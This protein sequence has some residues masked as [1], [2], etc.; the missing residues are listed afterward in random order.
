MANA[1]FSARLISRTNQRDHLPVSKTIK[2]VWK[3][4]NFSSHCLHICFC[5][6]VVAVANKKENSRWF[7]KN[8]GEGKKHIQPV[9]VS[10]CQRERAKFL[11]LHFFCSSCH[12]NDFVAGRWITTTPPNKKQS[13]ANQK[14][15]DSV[16]S[17]SVKWTVKSGWR[18]KTP[19]DYGICEDSPFISGFYHLLA[20]SFF[21]FCLHHSFIFSI[22]FSLFQK[23]GYQ[24]FF[25]LVSFSFATESYKRSEIQFHSFILHF[26]S[27]TKKKIII[28][29]F[30]MKWHLFS[31]NIVFNANYPI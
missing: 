4:I 24:R 22:Q 3:P 14:N 6:V 25:I 9:L 29:K 19:F 15:A 21:L 31:V 10:L 2:I 18:C 28:F 27:A 17:S 23:K 11:F 8:N 16:L 12:K 30:C 26:K 7:R 1:F 13:N 20:F 5:L